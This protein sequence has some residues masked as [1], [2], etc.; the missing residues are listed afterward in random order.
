MHNNGKSFIGTGSKA[1]DGLRVYVSP[2]YQQD[3]LA[4]ISR[5]AIAIIVNRTNIDGVGAII[6]TITVGICTETTTGIEAW[7]SS[8][9]I[10]T[11]LSV[12]V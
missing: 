2:G 8:L 11:S 12:I 7:Q 5:T 1:D 9:G 10:E 3:G 6:G 4:T